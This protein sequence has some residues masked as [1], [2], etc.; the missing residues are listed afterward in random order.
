MDYQKIHKK[1]ILL[2]PILSIVNLA[3]NKLAKFLNLN[4]KQILKHFSTYYLKNS[5]TFVDKVRDMEV[6]FTFIASFDV[7]SLF[8]NALLK[9]VIKIYVDS[10]YN[11]SIPTL[12]KI[13]F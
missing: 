6:T 3:Q 11:T 2:K 13:I 10:F 7:K 9:E 12:N 4:L 5:F 8:T 1:N